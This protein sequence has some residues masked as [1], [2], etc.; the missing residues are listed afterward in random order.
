MP[1]TRL[2]DTMGAN[3]PMSSRFEM[4]LVLAQ[5]LHAAVFTSAQLAPNPDLL[6]HTKQMNQQARHSPAGAVEPL[7]HRQLSIL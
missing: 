6:H 7:T 3:Q 1:V 4:Q 5:R 2:R